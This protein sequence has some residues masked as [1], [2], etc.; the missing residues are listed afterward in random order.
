M[1]ALHE[2]IS[3][4]TTNALAVFNSNGRG[5]GVFALKNFLA[6][7]VIE[8]APVIIIPCDQWHA[9]EKTILYNY[10]YAWGDDAALALGFGSLY[11]HAYNPNAAY[12][13]RIDQL[14]IEFIALRDIDAHEE[15]T[16]NYNSVPD[17]HSPLWFDVV[18]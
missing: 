11:N 18:S 5:R 17:D 13:K 12:L 2:S 9:T 16:I 10:C 7:E 15:I 14:L 4:V 6:G 3:T 1:L 8:R